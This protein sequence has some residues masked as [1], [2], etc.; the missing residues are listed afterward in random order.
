M[1]LFFLNLRHG[2]DELPNDHEPQEFPSLEEAKTEAIESLR[3][4]AALATTERR[5]MDYYDSI[6]IV[7]QDGR[8]L[9]AVTMLE[10][11]KQHA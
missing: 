8:L 7:S 4:I 6:D 5:R 2:L 10:A 3:E 1:A 9:L 11:V